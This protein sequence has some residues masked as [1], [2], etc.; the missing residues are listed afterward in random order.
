M[1]LLFCRI[2]LLPDGTLRIVNVTKTD[3]GSYTCL[4]RNQFGMA[5]TSGK[6]LVTGE[7]ILFSGGHAARELIHLLWNLS[8]FQTMLF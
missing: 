2:S 3:A 6:L 7:H 1:T 8:G 4:A 5:S